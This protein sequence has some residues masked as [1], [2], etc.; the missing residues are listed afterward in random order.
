MITVE[1]TYANP[2]CLGQ[3]DQYKGV[4]IVTHFFFFFLFFQ[5]DCLLIDI[6]ILTAWI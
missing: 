6:S 4:N 2:I 5:A 1:T 3:T